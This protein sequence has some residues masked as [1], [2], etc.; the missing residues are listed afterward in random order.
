VLGIVAAL[1]IVVSLILMPRQRGSLL[2][3]PALL[4]AVLPLCYLATVVQALRL[5]SE[6]TRFAAGFATEA[7]QIRGRWSSG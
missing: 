4:L 6:L 3:A 7:D 2:A 1:C 5:D